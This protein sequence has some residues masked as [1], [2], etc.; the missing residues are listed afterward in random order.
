MTKTL[1]IIA[2]QGILPIMVADNNAISDAKSVVVCIDGLALKT[3]Y[4]KHIAEEFQ[5]GQVSAILNFFKT[6]N[7]DKIVICGAMKRP[8]FSALS[9]DAK[10]AILLVKILAA[11]F[12][13][14]DQLL[15]IVAEYVEGQGFDVVSPIDYTNQIPIKTK[16]VP[17][18]REKEDIEIGLQASKKLGELDIG[19]AVI[20]DHGVVIGVE[21][22]EGTDSLIQRCKGLSK[23]GILV[24][25]LKLTQDARL[26]TPVIGVDTVNAIYEAG[27]AG[28]ALSGVIVLNPR[29]VLEEADRL[30]I[31]VLQA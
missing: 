8:K 19:Q 29:E 21:A 9:V 11:K 6:H 4:Q 14:D 3:D 13:G 27:M 18:K 31:F 17:S 5:I 2:A 30:G 15:R 12:L 26:D 16:R 22:I 23:S 24:K 1:G 20:V 7:V 25:C 10:G 28:I